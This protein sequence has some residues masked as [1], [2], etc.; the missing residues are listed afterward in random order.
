MLWKGQ[1]L[2]SQQKNVYLWGSSNAI[3]FLSPQQLSA[4]TQLFP[5][6]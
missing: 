2:P 1:L 3:A 4:T 5:K 6:D